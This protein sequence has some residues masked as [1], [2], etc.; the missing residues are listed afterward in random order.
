MGEGRQWNPLTVRHFTAAWVA[1]ALLL[2][3]AIDLPEAGILLIE[4]VR[5]VWQTHRDG[6]WEWNDNER[7]VWMAYQA[8]CV[9][10]ANSRSGPLGRSSATRP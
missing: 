2:A 10:G 4:A 1:R 7:P 5:R 3:S 8:V 6:Y 9:L